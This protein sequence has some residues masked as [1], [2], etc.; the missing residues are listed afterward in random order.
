MFHSGSRVDL[1]GGRTMTTEIGELQFR[2]N[3]RGGG[4]YW[5]EVFHRGLHKH[6]VLKG[7]DGQVII[8]KVRLQAAE[9]DS[10]WDKR[11]QAEHRANLANQTKEARRAHIEESKEEAAERTTEA[12]QLHETLRGLLV[13]AASSSEA[14]DWDEL[15]DRG[16]FPVPL[17]K[18]L[19]AEPAPQPTA[20]Q[21]APVLDSWRYQ[22]KLGLLDKL[23]SSRRQ[24]KQAEAQQ[25]FD[26][27]TRIWQ[28]DRDRIVADN[29]AQLKAHQRRERDRQ[30]EHDRAKQVWQGEKDAFLAKQAEQHAAIDAFQLRYESKEPSAIV[31]YCDMVLGNSDYPSCM[32]KEFDI[33]LNSEAGIL[34]VNYKLPAP[35]DIPTLC[36]VRYVQSTDTF[37]EKE[38]SES[39]LARLYDD[40]VYQ[41]SLRSMH[42][43]FAADQIGSLK[44]IVFNGFVTS[45]DKSTGNET[46]ACILSVQA[47][48]ETFE[49]INLSKVDPKACFRQLKGVGS[50]KMHSVTPIAPIMNVRR[51]DDRFVESYGV[52]ESLHE[53][54]NLASMDWEDFEHLIREIFAAEFAAGGGEVKVTQASRDGGVDAVAFDPDPIRGGKIVIQAKRYSHTVGVSA[55]RDLYGTLM[56]EGATKGVLVTTSDYGPDAYTFA[57]GKPISLLNGANLLHLLQKHG[58][59]AHINLAEARQTAAPQA[60]KLA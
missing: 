21:P 54:Y 60:G 8:A 20:V 40:L 36:E 52:A 6:R 43:L 12:E 39:Q 45:V 55:V 29:D 1:Y 18:N 56:N 25:R 27:D 5:L 4:S 47:N 31:E 9:W 35:D 24:I 51:D 14:I 3:S 33:D 41:I 38:L 57:N 16:Q 28:E 15:K 26:E 13:A 11:Q 48:R 49:K 22:P 17:P 32:P 50:S 53:G 2:Q 59:Q 58:I 7:P 30:A 37:T 23:I 44:A 10:L 34:V 46:T 19:R 42:E